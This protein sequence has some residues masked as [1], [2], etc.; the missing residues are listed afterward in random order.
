MLHCVNPQS[1]PVPREQIQSYGAAND[2]L[3]VWA[4]DCQFHH[5]P[6]DDPGN[7]G[8]TNEW[9][10]IIW[11]KKK[12]SSWM[13]NQS[14]MLTV[15][16]WR[17][18]TSARCIPVT[19]PSRAAN[20]CN[21]SPIMVAPRSTHSSWKKEGQSQQSVLL[22]GGVWRFTNIKKSN[23]ENRKFWRCV[24]QVVESRP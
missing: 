17:L 8:T 5:Q 2:L 15:G 13:G 24:Q 3:H 1:V 6:E 7:L 18:Q 23:H 20:L 19:T 16:Y 14:R 11:R 12:S 22:H 9:D 10:I 21:S 4:D